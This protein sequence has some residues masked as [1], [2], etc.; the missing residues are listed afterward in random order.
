MRQI[1]KN[2]GLSSRETNIVKEEESIGEE[3]DKRRDQGDVIQT[4]N[5]LPVKRHDIMVLCGGLFVR[6]SRAKVVIIRI[7][8]QGD[9]DGEL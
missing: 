7:C 5:V 6:T 3:D 4:G 2:T 9:V 1:I 8:L